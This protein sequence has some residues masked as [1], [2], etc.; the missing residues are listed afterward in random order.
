[1][2][3]HEED[4]ECELFARYLGK[5]QNEGKV[6]KFAHIN[7]E[8]YTRSWSQKRRIVAMGTPAGLPDYI[9]VARDQDENDTLIFIEMKKIKGG[10]LSKQQREWGKALNE[11]GEYYFVC[12]GFKEAKSLVET[13]IEG[14]FNG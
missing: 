4:I 9:I 10:V 1:M 5:M 12:N 3:S 8:V 14:S 6:V 11:A 7:S 13:I 2:R